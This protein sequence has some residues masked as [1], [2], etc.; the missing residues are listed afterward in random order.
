MLVACSH[1]ERERGGRE[2]EREGGREGGRER[3]SEGGRERGREGERRGEGGRE[4][5]REEG[6]REGGVTYHSTSI[7]THS[8]TPH[9]S[10]MTLGQRAKEKVPTST[11]VVVCRFYTMYMTLYMYLKSHDVVKRVTV[12][13]FDQAVFTTGEQQM[14]PW[15]KLN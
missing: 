1:T 13:T 3:G 10:K 14:G 2:G 8:Q 11:T 9:L 6:G 7:V 15:D 4:G 12:P 5:G